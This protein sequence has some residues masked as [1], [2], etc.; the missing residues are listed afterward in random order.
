MK[1]LMNMRLLMLATLIIPLFASCGDDDDNE[2]SSS[3][4][5]K[6]ITKIIEESQGSIRESLLTYD[7]QGRVVEVK[8]TTNS[9]DVTNGIY[10]KTYQYGESLIIQKEDVD[11]DPDNQYPRTHTYTLSGGLIVKDTEIKKET[12]IYNH[13]EYDQDGYWIN[14]LTYY[15]M[16]EIPEYLYRGHHIKWTNGNLSG[17][18]YLGADMLYNYST[19]PWVQGMIYDL[20]PFTDPILYAEGYYGKT[21]KYLPSDFDNNTY[22]YSVSDGLVTKIT[23]THTDPYNEKY[24]Y[25]SVIKY[26]WE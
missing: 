26:I 20:T 23:K 13:F 21:P 18:E 14:Y 17:I 4:K 9:A 16:D 2:S 6:R 24:S 10:T 12:P 1:H 11:N 25:T 22:Q 8:M 3:S 19:T 7:V 15:E 5:G